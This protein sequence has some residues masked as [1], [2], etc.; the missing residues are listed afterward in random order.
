MEYLRVIN[1]EKYQHY[2]DRR[3]QWIKLYWSLL[4]SPG[5]CSAS[6]GMHVGT[7]SVTDQSKFH[8]IAIM[9]LAS[10]Y[11]N[12]IPYNKPWI[13]RVIHANNK[14]NWDHVLGCGI[15]ECYQDA[16]T[17]VADCKQDAILEKR[18]VY[19][20]EESSAEAQSSQPASQTSSNSFTVL[21]CVGKM[22]IFEV[23][24]EYVEEMKT[25]YPGVDIE[26]ETLL[27]KGWLI[28][29]P[30]KGKTFDGIM[31][32][33]GS[34]YTKA[35]N[36][37]KNKPN[38]NGSGPAIKRPALKEGLP[39]GYEWQRDVDGKVIGCVKL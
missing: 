12:K 39:E 15:V 20:E 32:F 18:R 21:P 31:R 3:P 5:L 9:L 17:E 4:S 23:S 29:N 28:N 27:A 10:Q 38:G 33:L 6:R 14:I 24:K 30:K 35:Q 37:S 34:W 36:D 11:G 25:L 26:R 19:K 7:V 13:A 22:Q 8:I 1:L 2:R 16:S